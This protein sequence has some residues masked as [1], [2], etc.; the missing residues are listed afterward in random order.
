M[1]K[2]AGWQVGERPR[3]SREGGAAWFLFPLYFLHLVPL[4]PQH[5]FGDIY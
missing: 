4:Q 3:G 1:S 5:P 2:E